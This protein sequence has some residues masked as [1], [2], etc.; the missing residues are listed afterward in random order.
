MVT[1]TIITDYVAEGTHAARPATP[2][3]PAGATSIYYETDTTNTFAWSGS[4]WVQINS[5][6]G[7]ATIVQNGSNSGTI[8]GVTL[9]AAPTL[10]NLL[11]AFSVNNTS[12]S[13][14]SGWTSIATNNSIEFASIAYK[15]AGAG[16]SATQ[17][18]MGAAGGATCSIF[19]IHLG[20]LS[21]AAIAL[22][23][24]AATGSV[25][26]VA[27]KASGVLI[28]AVVNDSNNVLPTSIVGATLDSN[29][30]LATKSTQAYHLTP[31]QGVNNIAYVY[32]A[33]H[34]VYAMGVCVF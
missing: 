29:S 13:I 12:G 34:N 15:I 6:G 27:T 25:N 8:T 5:A 14:G 18:P 4:A 21:L 19:E 10:G 33:S 28:G 7:G 30:A 20:G 1:S 22:V 26:V 23:T 16:E 32:A 11:V 24:A 9:G 3:I 17:N 2:N 31:A